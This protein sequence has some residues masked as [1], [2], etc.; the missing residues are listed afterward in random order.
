MESP[1]QEPQKEEA[2]RPPTRDGNKRTSAPKTPAPSPSLCAVLSPHFKQSTFLVTKALIALNVLAFLGMVVCSGGAGFM[3]PS[4]DLLK[5]WGADFGPLTLNGDYWRVVTSMFLH[6]GFIHLLVNM[7]ALRSLGESCERLLGSGKFLAVYFIAGL[8]GNIASLLLNP[9]VLS[10]GASGAIFGVYGALFAFFLAHRD[11][12]NKQALLNGS[13][14]AAAF[15]VYNLFL[16]FAFGFDNAAHIGGLLTGLLCGY[17]CLQRSSAKVKAGATLLVLGMIGTFCV[18]RYAPFDFSGQYKHLRILDKIQHE[19][20]SLEA[21]AALN[22]LCKQHPNTANF[23][24]V[25]AYFLLEF[26][27]YEEAVKDFDLVVTLNTPQRA[28]AYVGRAEALIGLTRFKEALADAKEGIKLGKDTAATH[29]LCAKASLGTGDS[30][31]A[32]E[33]CAEALKLDPKVSY[34]V[35][36]IRARAWSKQNNDTAAVEDLSKAILLEPDNPEAHMAR[37]NI[38]AKAHDFKQAL[39]DI[40]YVREKAP[41]DLSSLIMRADIYKQMDDKKRALAD[42]EETTELVKKIPDPKKPLILPM[43]NYVRAITLWHFGER[44]AAAADAEKVCLAGWKSTQSP[45]CAIWAVICFRATGQEPKADQM[46]KDAAEKL[47][48]S[49][50]YPVVPYLQGKLSQEELFKMADNNDKL[51]EAK[52]YV[53]LNLKARGEALPARDFLQWVVDHGTK[54]FIEYDLS[55][56]ELKNYYADANKKQN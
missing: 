39:A 30:K 24:S 36:L 28:S 56:Q 31:S 9:V 37:A 7:A 50:P 34:Q 49:W 19:G 43:I 25:R 27:R 17:L 41:S 14:A 3:E 11:T 4:N 18:A 45:Y 8:A 42:L 46:L 47:A 5:K 20:A 53:G 10:A 38:Y 12:M 52:A 40:N 26:H 55:Q 22:E 51:T 6:I 44:A 21:F 29:L 2:N 16:G 54:T 1:N 48:K 23:R 32:I 15:I 33:E 13:R 35:C